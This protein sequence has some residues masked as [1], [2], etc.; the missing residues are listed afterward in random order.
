[1]DNSKIQEA[2]QRQQ[3]ELKEMYMDP[4]EKLKL[5]NKRKGEQD[6]AEE[7]AAE[8]KENLPP[9]GMSSQEYLGAK[10]LFEVFDDRKGKI[11]RNRMGSV[12]VKMGMEPT[13]NEIKESQ[14]KYD[15]NGA[16]F[17]NIAL[18]DSSTFIQSNRRRI[19]RFPRVCEYGSARQTFK[20]L[21]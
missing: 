2:I 15:T 12:L 10:A 13:D 17:L 1:M 11:P 14:A 21:S 8:A 18:C 9:E 7:A 4:L 20:C 19:Y 5:D 16:I 3:E 6:A